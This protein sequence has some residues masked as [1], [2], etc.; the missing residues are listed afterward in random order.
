MIERSDAAVTVSAKLFDVIPF[1]LALILLAPTP[2][3][4]AKAPALKLA[5]AGFEE[6]QVAEFVI[7]SVVPSASA[8][9]AVN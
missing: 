3:P 6:L 7:L 5:A 9:I 8:A 1:W 4:V 2:M